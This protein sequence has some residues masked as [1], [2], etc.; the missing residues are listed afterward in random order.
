MIEDDHLRRRRRYILIAWLVTVPTL[1]VAMWVSVAW[2][3]PTPPRVV[4]MA[5]DSESSAS[6]EIAARYR[7]ILARDGIE[8][9]LIPTAGA[10]DSV[11]RMRD[12]HSGISI[13]IV[14]SGITNTRESPNLVSLGTLFY[15]PLWLFYHGREALHSREGLRGATI[16]I[17]AEGSGTRALSLEFMAQAGIIDEHFAKFV[18]LPPQEA[19]E[20]LL[21]GDINAAVLLAPWESP[22]VRQLVSADDIHLLPIQYADAYV[23]LYPYLSEVVLPAGVGDIAK[24]R[25]P[26]D[27]VLLAPKASLVVR[28]DLHPAIQYVLLKAAQEIHSGPG[29]F[30]KA[31]QF[32][33]PESI[34]LP[35]SDN[36]LQFY[37]SG[38]PFLQRHLPFRLAVL[39]QQLLVLLIPVF[40]VLYPL[41]RLAPAMYGWT[42][43]H[44]VYSLY[45][46]LKFLEQDLA[47]RT[48]LDDKTDLV[49]RLDRL[50]E[51][52]S[53]FRVPTAFRPLL[54]TLRLHISLIR[55]RLEH[56]PP[57]V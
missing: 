28:D 2:F 55:Q 22:L 24:R 19:V 50:D 10:V 20:R 30:R 4:A 7:E 37:K 43:R 5:A 8:L 23:A 32:P 53:R 45:G 44:R 49:A 38:R 11:A 21:H 47:S 51:R 17:G 14:P 13:A 27:V 25:P 57:T 48:A 31:G 3:S 29:L 39:A 46:E 1:I 9:R 52:A 41:L 16:S 18:S 6:G 42:M 35:L 15:E 40:G 12:S 26:D 34:D 36:A 33:A 54:Y 56:R